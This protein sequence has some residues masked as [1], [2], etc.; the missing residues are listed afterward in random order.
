MVKTATKGFLFKKMKRKECASHGTFELEKD[1][2]GP[3]TMDFNGAEKLFT[4]TI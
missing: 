4:A 2:H 3:N 1:E